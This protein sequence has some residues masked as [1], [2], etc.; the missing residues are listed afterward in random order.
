MAPHRR[1]RAWLLAV[2]LMLGAGRAWA[3]G[4]EEV[5]LVVNARSK[6]GRE[7]ADYYM[8]RRGIPKGN[9]LL[10]RTPEVETIDAPTYRERIERPLADYL[11]NPIRKDAPIRCLLLFYGLPLRINAMD[12]ALKEEVAVQ[13]KMRDDLKAARSALVDN[14][15][16]RLELEARLKAVEAALK[17]LS[18]QTPRASVDSELAL[19]RVGE[20]ERRGWLPNPYHIGFRNQKLSLSKDQ[21]LMVSRLDGPSP[22]IVRRMIDDA[23]VTEKIGLKGAAC[24][25]ARWP[26][27]EETRGL[28][29]YKR[30]DYALH[31]WAAHLEA[32]WSGKRYF[33]ETDALFGPGACP[34]TALYCGWYSLSRYVDAFTWQPG[35]VAY[36][37]A[38]GECS[39]LKTP[40][41][42]VWCKRL[43]EEGVAATLGPVYE[44][45]VQAFPLPSLFFGLLTEGYLTLVECYQVSLPFLSWQMVLLGDPLYRPFGSHH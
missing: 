35:S 6:S 31:Q 19:V 34:E 21:V 40:G 43:L 37:I 3:L 2:L 18:T 39:T 9:Q 27:P 33:D 12:P 41:S 30:Y 45:Y 20:H 26:A 38:S 13:K 32:H 22:E 29:G 36:H 1:I 14:D 8:L 5:L 7:L 16:R 23:L 44:P 24:V 28:S 11:N 25:D 15:P 42:Q 17:H 10:L 4:P